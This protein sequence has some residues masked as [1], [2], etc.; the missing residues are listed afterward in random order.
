MDVYNINLNAGQSLVYFG[1]LFEFEYVHL[2]KTTIAILVIVIVKII[3]AIIN[4]I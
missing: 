3:A 2:G 4:M 1:C